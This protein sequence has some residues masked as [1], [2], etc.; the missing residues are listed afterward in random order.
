MMSSIE[1]DLAG[2]TSARAGA[3]PRDRT[4]AG[5][6]RIELVRIAN[7]PFGFVLVPHAPKGFKA[8]GFGL[9][10]TGFLLD[11]LA[12]ERRQPA[13]ISKAGT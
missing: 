11:V 8:A 5:I 6:A 3:P 9:E 7:F 1:F 12:R 13:A 4:I 10:M 2:Q